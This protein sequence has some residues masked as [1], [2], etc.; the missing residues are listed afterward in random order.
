MFFLLEI[1]VFFVVISLGKYR[2][3]FGGSYQGFVKHRLDTVVSGVEMLFFFSEGFAPKMDMIFP[4]D[5]QNTCGAGSTT[6]PILQG[7]FGTCQMG[8]SSEPKK[9][10]ASP[11]PIINYHLTPGSLD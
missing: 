1:V 8:I 5:E 2:G 3:G 6:N 4:I 7:E 10:T 11:Y 9:I